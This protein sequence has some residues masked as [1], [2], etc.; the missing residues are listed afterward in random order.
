LSS[1]PNATAFIHLQ[2]SSLQQAGQERF[3]RR[4]LEIIT[5]VARQCVI[6]SFD[7]AAVHHVRQTSSLRIGWILSE[8]ST[9]SALKCEALAPDYVFCDHALLT[10]TTS[11]L[12]RGSW[13]WAVYEVNR[14]KLA[15]ELAGREARLIE[16]TAFR[17]MLR[18][19]REIK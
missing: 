11:R 10:Q 6:T 8:Y 1:Y 7:L 17:E 13:R 19:F 9:L 3:V 16:T 5:P 12:W 2:R 4:V 18:Q 15:L 14:R